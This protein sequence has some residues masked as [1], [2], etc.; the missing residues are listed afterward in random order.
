MIEII[1]TKDGS[2][3]LRNTVLNETYH[4]IHGAVQESLHVFIK[5]GL[6]FVVESGLKEI[7]VLEIG[8]G[9]GLNAWLTAKHAAAISSSLTY[10][11]F[12]SFPLD[13]SIWS[14][15][16]YATNSIEQELFSKIH[17]ATWNQPIS[18]TPYF[19]LHKINQALQE[20][21]LPVSQFDSIYFDAFAPDKQ[22][23]MW[24]VPIFK[25]I[26]AAMKPG[27]VLVTYCAK[28]QVKRDL[29]S[30][31]LQVETLQGPPGKREMIR[32]S[33]R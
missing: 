8:F 27:A 7:S 10:T 28:G 21:V 6:E 24:A 19:T 1:L 11:S 12:E 30:V 15:L 4:S 31:G 13:E 18:I 33:K 29:K 2:H 20:A 14:Q 26:V 22:P 17:Q 16:N 9:T 25:K 23:E 5:H 32:A 3:T